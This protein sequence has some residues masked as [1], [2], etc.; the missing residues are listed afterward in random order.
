MT[1]AQLAGWIAWLSREPRGDRRQDLRMALQTAHIRSAWV[2]NDSPVESFLP[3]FQD[4]RR[5]IFDPGTT[6][7]IDTFFDRMQLSM[8]GFF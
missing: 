6:D 2:E 7:A 5:A 3:N 4:A 1:Y 8:E